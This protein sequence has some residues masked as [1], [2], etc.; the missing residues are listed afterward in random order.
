MVDADEDILFVF[1]TAAGWLLVCE[2]SIRL[3]YDQK[4]ISRIEFGGVISEAR[5]EGSK[6]TVRDVY[7]TANQ[8]Q[9]SESGLKVTSD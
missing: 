3:V 6:L 8:L 9:V 1:P 4:T 7:G 2:T 5:L